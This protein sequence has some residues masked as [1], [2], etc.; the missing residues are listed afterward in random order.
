MHLSR[1]AQ[2]RHLWNYPKKIKGTFY[3]IYS[4][5]LELQPPKA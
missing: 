5:P 1:L 2:P 4:N 3:M